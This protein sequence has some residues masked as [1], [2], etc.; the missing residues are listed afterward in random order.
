MTESRA[1]I[2]GLLEQI[3]VD[4]QA[5]SDAV[6]DANGTSDYQVR[7]V[8]LALIARHYLREL[9]LLR[10]HPR[11][12]TSITGLLER[13]SERAAACDVCPSGDDEWNQ[14]EA[15]TLRRCAD[16]LR[17]QP[18]P[19]PTELSDA[20]IGLKQATRFAR[21]LSDLRQLLG[22][23]SC[24]FDELPKLLAATLAASPAGAPPSVPSITGIP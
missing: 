14:A 10:A 17:A 11:E 9:A 3:V 6:D 4:M 16:E 24:T 8:A 19:N 21:I 22:R 1:R 13:W 15:H 5:V 23:D 12:D 18:S 20:A 7:L 2:A